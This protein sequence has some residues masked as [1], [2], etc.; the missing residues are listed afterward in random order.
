[1]NRKVERV[2]ST[3]QDAPKQAP[4]AQG[5]SEHP[6]QRGYTAQSTTPLN[7]SDLKPPKGDTA[8]QPPK[9]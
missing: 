9:K 4:G 7:A 6:E 8:V 5:N 3:S 1:M 2:E